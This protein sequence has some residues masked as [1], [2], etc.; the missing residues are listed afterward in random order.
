MRHRCGACSHLL[1]CK[2]PVEGRIP[3]RVLGAL[4]DHAER[5]AWP[6]HPGHATHAD[7]QVASSK[8]VQCMPRPAAFHLAR[9]ASAHPFH[10]ASMGRCCSAF[11]PQIP[12][13]GLHKARRKLQEHHDVA[14][15]EGRR[16]RDG[17]PGQEQRDSCVHRFRHQPRRI[18]NLQR[19]RAIASLSIGRSM[20]TGQRKINPQVA[21]R[22]A[23]QGL[24]HM[25]CTTAGT[26]HPPSAAA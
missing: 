26:R 11:Y 20:A 2:P 9:G 13:R 3:A 7:Q 12:G 10:A 8:Q 22:A 19:G 17:H 6:K 5:P 21:A 25:R 24:Q 15:W 16:W 14:A 18:L 1:L 23:A 4:H